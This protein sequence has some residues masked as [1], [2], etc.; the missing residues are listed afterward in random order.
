MD[1]GFCHL[2][3]KV[4]LHNYYLLMRANEKVEQDI[5]EKFSGLR[6]QEEESKAATFVG[7]SQEEAEEEEDVLVMMGDESEE[8][9]KENENDY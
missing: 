7:I 9:T 5:T 4:Q 3:V 8:D 6:V 1:E 2:P